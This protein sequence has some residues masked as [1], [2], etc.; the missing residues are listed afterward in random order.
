MNGYEELKIISDILLVVVGTFA[1]VVYVL[2]ERR[3]KIN[4]AALIVIQI[5]E[6]QSKIQ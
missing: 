4:A 2:Q 1:L 5:D 6:L 3:K